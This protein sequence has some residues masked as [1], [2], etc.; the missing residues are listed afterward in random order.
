VVYA[1]DARV[2]DGAVT[3]WRPAYAPPGN[4]GVVF[5][6]ERV[7]PTGGRRLVIVQIE[8]E[9]TR[10]V[11]IRAAA[12]R[13]DRWSG[14]FGE[15]GVGTGITFQSELPGF[16]DRTWIRTGRIRVFG[17][18]VDARD[19]ARFTFEYE[20]DGVRRAAYGLLET[21]LPVTCGNAPSDHV[22]IGAV[23]PEESRPFVDDPSGLP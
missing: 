10:T 13:F 8:R 9:P 4:G 12:F 14:A 15:D 19:P 5:L 7:G 21:D 6:H 16:S 22:V 20:I 2:S 1:E 11:R 17:G 3:C 18:E 23:P